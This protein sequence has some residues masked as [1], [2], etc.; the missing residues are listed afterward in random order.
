[1]ADAPP[2]IAVPIAARADQRAAARFGVEMPLQIDGQATV[3]HDLSANG[4]C[5]ESE[6]A[7]A[8]GE[9]VAVVIEYLL[10]G[11]NYP[12]K[13]QVEVVRCEASGGR[14]MVGARLLSPLAEGPCN[15][16]P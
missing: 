3:T 11:H 10:D 6:R 15:V 13:C 9:Q 2:R 5:F 1:M 16:L 12:L 7:Y 8:P 4:L 14:F